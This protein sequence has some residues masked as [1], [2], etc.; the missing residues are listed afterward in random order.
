MKE[1]K[2]LS[3]NIDVVILCKGCFGDGWVYQSKNGQCGQVKDCPKCEG[4][5][6]VKM[7]IPTLIFKMILIK[8]D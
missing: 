7:S 1:E 8:K 4:S 2:Q 3:N 5:G 6:V